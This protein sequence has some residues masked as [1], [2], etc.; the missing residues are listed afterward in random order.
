[1]KPVKKR[2]LAAILSACMA[3]TALPAAALTALADSVEQT[4]NAAVNQTTSVQYATLAQAVAEAQDGQ[5]IQLLRSENVSGAGKGKNEAAILIDDDIVLDGAGHTITAVDFTRD[6]SGNPQTHILSVQNG[7]QA[8][9]QNL[10]IQGSADTKHG[11]NV[12]AADAASGVNLTLADVSI[13]DCGT[14][15]I[16][17][18]HSQVTAAGLTTS[19]NVW[20]AV[21][22]DNGSHFT[23]TGTANQ[24]KESVKLWTE[25]PDGQG[26]VTIDVSQSNLKPVKGE[27]TTL[28]GY[29]YYTD[30][31]AELGEGYNETTQTVY[32][33]L[34][35]A[36]GAVS[37]GQRLRVVRSAALDSAATLPA[38]ATLAVDAGVTLTTNDQLTS[39][40]EIVNQGSISGQVTASEP[41]DADQYRVTYLA[42][43]QMWFTTVLTQSGG[44][45]TFPQPANPTKQGHTFV[46][47][48]YGGNVTVSD[49]TVTLTVESA[50]SYTF[51]A[52]WAA[53]EEDATHTIT[54]APAQ[55]GQVT[56]SLPSAAQGTSVTL[57]VTPDTGYALS[58][59]TVSGENGDVA[60]TDHQDGTYTFTMPDS[61]V[62]V[63]AVFVQDSQEQ[64]QLPF[65]DVPQD[66]W[67]YQSVSYI[68]DRGL[69]Q[70]VADGQFAP[71]SL[72]T[73]GMLMTILAR[74][75]GEDT[76]GGALWYDKGL[77]WAVDRG[78]SDGTSPEGDITREQVV[79]MLYRYAGSP[80]VSG[81]HLS[82]FPDSASV[83][84]WAQDAM[85]WAVSINL[86]QGRGDQLAP[87][88]EA[89]RCELSTLLHRFCM[90]TGK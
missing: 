25:K 6:G 19:G 74:L 71:Q 60:V 81:D 68:W 66:S 82:A 61:P 73:R 1:M 45:L 57:T 72:S 53:D 75:D 63:T 84:G 33:D 24:M 22:V 14:A 12:W 79:T 85:N 55:N 69:M 4:G 87:T 80:A 77:A 51:Q 11:I 27:G 78:V 5:T 3:M 15:G 64:P 34:D 26:A 49:G 2:L 35:A 88:G 32:E 31:V 20:G 70:G 86:I 18:N 28:K 29:T 52:Q 43:G 17:V 47:W 13:L 67:Y 37:V 16:V 30:N 7:A 38:G 76:S 48:D 39:E 10:T 90:S 59:L 8:T 44:Q 89:L 41:T 50:K 54:V 42:D 58:S 62:T 36:L 9:I 21:N 56:A 65:H 23:L 83:S 46:G 40:G